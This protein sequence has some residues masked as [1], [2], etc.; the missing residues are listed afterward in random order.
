M[1]EPAAATST[2]THSRPVQRTRRFVLLLLLPF[3]FLAV[4][5]ALYLNGGRFVETDNAYVKADVLPISAEVSGAVTAV[6]V[7]A[8]EPV[9]ENQLLF[10]L[11]QQPFQ[12][13]V[14]KAQANLARVRT[15]LE[16]LKSSYR[17]KEA[18]IELAES[19]HKFASREFA[20]QQDLKGRNFVSASALDDLEHAVDLS[21]Q[22]L[23]V[24][25]LDL[26]R[27]AASLGGT[28]DRPLEQHPTYLAALAD[29]DEA[30]LNLQR[31]EVRAP[32]P[33][34]LSKAPLMGQYIHAGNMITALV[35][36]DAPWIEANFTETDLTHVHVG[37]QV[38]VH[39]D[40]Y[41]DHRWRGVVESISPATGAEFSIIPAQNA[42][43]N[44]VKIPQRVPIR[45]R[46]EPD[47]DAP[48]LRAGFSALVEID[49]KHKRKLLGFSF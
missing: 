17:E 12:V 40:T 19:N 20:R 6:F 26:K 14:D 8:N 9:A 15:E 47:A 37:Q 48:D 31:V 29:L 11:D 24:I 42:T 38:S 27:I 5:L 23:G 2:T 41:P 7:K 35:A 21:R 34:V 43:G 44:W 30:R 46:L 22:E 33:G 45:V 39:I 1:T 3:V 13:A 4:S 36:N 32:L 18:R 28:I 25:K 49:T 10:S 16:A